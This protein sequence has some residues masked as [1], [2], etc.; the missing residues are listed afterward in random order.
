M[1]VLLKAHLTIT[2]TQRRHHP[3]PPHV[4]NEMVNFAN[5]VNL[6]TDLIALHLLH[7]SSLLVF[8]FFFPLVGF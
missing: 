7:Y 3:P 8:F 1:F 4:V 2:I 6:H 5:D